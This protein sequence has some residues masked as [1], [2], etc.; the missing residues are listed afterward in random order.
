MGNRSGSNCVGS[1]R[2]QGAS[3]EAESIG[4][5][6]TLKRPNGFSGRLKGLPPGWAADEGAREEGRLAEATLHCKGKCA[7]V[8]CKDLSSTLS[9]HPDRHARPKKRS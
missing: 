8:G 7:A 5:S 1:R 4:L 2:N 6:G 9:I 3:N